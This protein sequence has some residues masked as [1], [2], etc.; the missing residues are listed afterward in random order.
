MLEYIFS[1]MRKILFA[2]MALLL[3]LVACKAPEPV[4][5]QKPVEVVCPENYMRI[6]TTC[7]LDAN[8]NE[9]CDSDEPAPVEEEAPLAP[10][11]ESA[12][13]SVI[14]KVYAKAKD[15]VEQG[16][17][18]SIMDET[19]FVRD[20]KMKILFGDYIKLGYDYENM[21]LNLVDTA[22][23]NLNTKSAFGVCSGRFFRSSS[24][25]Q[26]CSVLEGKKFPLYFAD[27]Y[28]KTP[29]DWLEEFKDK[30]PIHF[31]EYDK[32]IRRRYTD[33]VIFD[34]GATLVYMWVD[35]ES[36]LPIRIQIDRKRDRWSVGYY[37]YEDLVFYLEPE[38]VVYE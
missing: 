2:V 29:M 27:Y 1:I 20:N 17:S 21:R 7:C 8:D 34:E 16:Y 4:V 23:L 6:G 12:Q 11:T 33:V 19:F 10:D 32:E 35:H 18:F 30:T 24:L 22:Y 26:T 36:G 37:E 28:Y 9:I 38:E 3:V 5:V 15:S 31:R 25:D 13:L 14:E